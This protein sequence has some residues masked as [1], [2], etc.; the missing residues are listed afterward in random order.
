MAIDDEEWS[1]LM[2]PVPV[3]IKLAINDGK[4]SLFMG[5]VPVWIEL[6]VNDEEWSLYM[7]P[8]PRPDPTPVGQLTRVHFILNIH[9]QIFIHVQV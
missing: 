1:L 3:W 9:R 6:A 7:G 4:W 8:V 2:G 5:P